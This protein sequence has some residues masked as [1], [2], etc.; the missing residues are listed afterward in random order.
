MFGTISLDEIITTLDKNMG[1]I[2][3][4][5]FIPCSYAVFLKEARKFDITDS[6]IDYELTEMRYIRNSIGFL[7]KYIAKESPITPII[8]KIYKDAVQAIIAMQE[9]QLD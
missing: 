1:L 5:G 9:E 4:A 3:R 2:E 7:R 6:V 8:D